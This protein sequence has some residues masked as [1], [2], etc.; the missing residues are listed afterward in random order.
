M[1][2]LKFL[3][4][5]ITCVVFFASNEAFSCS[6]SFDRYQKTDL[7][8]FLQDFDKNKP[9]RYA[10]QMFGLSGRPPVVFEGT[11]FATPQRWREEAMA[12]SFKGIEPAPPPA[13]YGILVESKASRLIM[14]HAQDSVAQS[15][16]T[17]IRNLESDSGSSFREMPITVWAIHIANVSN[18]PVL[19]VTCA[20]T[21]DSQ[22]RQQQKK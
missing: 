2:V 8:S 1:Q 22:L 4:S 19:L 7:D 14:F 13:R 10:I 21:D 18:R 3:I 20:S 17:Q 12:N 15:I 11:L 5:F 16:I 6:G 9:D